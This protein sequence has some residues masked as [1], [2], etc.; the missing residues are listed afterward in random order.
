VAALLSN[1]VPGDDDACALLSG[2]N[3]DATLLV[4]VVRHGLARSGRYLVLRSRVIDQPGHLLKLLELVAELRGN[5]L[6]V[7][8]DRE[9]FELDVAE[10]GIELTVITRDEHHARELVGALEARG[11]PV[12]VRTRSAGS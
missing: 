7:H 1:R 3:I 5:I 8:H 2:G 10:T 4:S 11:Y 12:E 9:G 6:E